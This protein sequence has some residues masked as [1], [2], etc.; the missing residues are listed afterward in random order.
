M[1]CS[2]ASTVPSPG[3]I[4]EASLMSGT[5]QGD[6]QGI[7]PTGRQ[8]TGT[9]MTF[10]RLRDGKVVHD[11]FESSSPPLEQQLTGQD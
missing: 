6:Y 1:F 3:I 7:A 10:L 4:P 9:G 8:V 5:H 11:R 2:S